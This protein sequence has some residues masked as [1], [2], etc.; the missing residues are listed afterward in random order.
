MK[1]KRTPEQ[2][3]LYQYN[4]AYRLAHPEIY[5]EASKRWQRKNKERRDAYEKEYRNSEPVKERKKSYNQEY[6]QNNLERERERDRRRYQENR[7]KERERAKEYRERNYEKIEA[8]RILRLYGVTEN[9]YKKLIELQGSVCAICG[10]P[11]SSKKRLHIDHRHTDGVV[12]GLLCNNC[13]IIL[14][15]AKDSIV[16]L[17][18]AISYLKNHL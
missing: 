13:N 3:K 9:E 7:E 2:E 10:L 15:H 14:G 6:R 5:Q 18:S 4:K 11:P 8:R 16:T 12:R 17:E 1:N